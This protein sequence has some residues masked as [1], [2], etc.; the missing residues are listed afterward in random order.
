MFM[1][2]CVCVLGGR[3][4]RL[5]SNEVP[6]LPDQN[7]YGCCH[8]VSDYLQRA[9]FETPYD[10]AGFYMEHPLSYHRHEP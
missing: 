4:L 5:T 10:P 6:L 7:K 9:I 2:V 1:C 3:D 8:F